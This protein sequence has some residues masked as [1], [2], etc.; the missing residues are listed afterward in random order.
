MTSNSPLPLSVALLAGGSGSRL[1]GTQKALIPWKKGTLLSEFLYTF[2][3]VTDDLFVITNHPL[4]EPY[5]TLPAYP[6]L[7]P[8]KGPLSGIHTALSVSKHPLVLIVACDMPFVTADAASWLLQ[9]ANQKP[10]KVII[11][12]GI[13]GPEP[14]FGIWPVVVLNVLEDWLRKD[15]PLKIMHF[16][17]YHSLVSIV[18]SDMNRIDSNFFFNIN[19]PEDLGATSQDTDESSG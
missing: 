3:K 5:H 17:E 9:H 7:I 10:Q 6:D 19:T 11:P 8:G 13:H 15:N 4:P 1:G 12:Q 14:M 2:L 18:P 16:L